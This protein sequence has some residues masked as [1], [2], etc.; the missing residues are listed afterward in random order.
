MILTMKAIKPFVEIMGQSERAFVAKFTENI[1]KGL[2]ERLENL[3]ET[4]IKELDK[5]IIKETINVMR[6]YIHILD[7]ENSAQIAEI[8]ELRI[9]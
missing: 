7:P 1:K 9:A 8:Y 6:S 5:E 2:M 3:T 4:E